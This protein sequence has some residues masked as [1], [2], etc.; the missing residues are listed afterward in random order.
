[1]SV[2]LYNSRNIHVLL[3]DPTELV[4][5]H[6]LLQVSGA[7]LKNDY[8]ALIK[9]VCIFQGPSSGVAIESAK[10]FNLNHILLESFNILDRNF[11]SV[12]D[13][14]T[15]QIK[16]IVLPEQYK[17]V[18]WINQVR[19]TN[20]KIEH[21]EVCRIL[22]HM[23]AW[24]YSMKKNKPIIVMEHDTILNAAHDF[25]M[26]RNSINALATNT[27]NMHNENYIC[28]HKPYAYS[29]DQFSSK[30]LFN[31]IMEQGIREPMEFMIRI[32]QFNVINY[33]KVL[34]VKNNF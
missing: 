26:P 9:D 23:M 30:R 18:E 32:D 13:Y 6:Q 34:R 31:L 11:I 1:M 33:S 5:Q 7:N 25:H 15:L 22:N 17:N 8:S 10:R 24:H 4:D 27:Y 2:A 16:E 12:D 29:V 21:N 14:N 28:M 3:N 20:H 19:L